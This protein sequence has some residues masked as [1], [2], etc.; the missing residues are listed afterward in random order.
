M[1]PTKLQF[2]QN[3]IK[4]LGHAISGKGIAISAHRVKAI[5]ALPEPE[6]TEDNRG[7]LDT[8]NYVRRCIDGYAEKP[9]PLVEPAR[10]DYVI[11]IDFQTAFGPA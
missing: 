6:C 7:V 5:L 3:E 11:N 2:G 9:A 8:L 10:K 1:K 4:Y